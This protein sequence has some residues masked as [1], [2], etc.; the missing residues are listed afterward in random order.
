MK[1]IFLLFLS[2]S[3][4][5]CNFGKEKNIKHYFLQLPDSYLDDLSVQERQIIL[6]EGNYYPAGND[7]FEAIVY[8]LERF[9]RDKDFLRI[10][11]TF[12]TGQ[13]GFI[14][15]ELRK[16]KKRKG[17]NIIVFSSV[18]GAHNMFGNNEICVFEDHNDTIKLS[19]INY[20]PK[21]INLNDFLKPGTP[22]LIKNKYS[23]YASNCYELGY[24]NNNIRHQLYDAQINCSDIDTSFI[25]GNVI[26]FEWTGDIFKRH[27]VKK[28][29]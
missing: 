4:I 11:M 16:F 3:L 18:S 20:F 1:H 17:G 5:S 9:D 10:E 22:E 28:E 14:I 25:K 8:S 26:E 21:N 29:R 6:K 2:V 24:F 19:N 15:Y 23:E 12:E 13:A 27:K 7:E